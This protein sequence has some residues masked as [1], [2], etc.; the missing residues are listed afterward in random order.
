MNC[1]DTDGGVI[2]GKLTWEETSQ[3]DVRIDLSLFDYR[4]KVTTDYYRYT[5]GQ[6]N[7]VDLP[8][9]YFLNSNGKMHCCFRSGIEVELTADILR[10]SR[11]GS[12]EVENEI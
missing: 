5:K 12:Y 1:S 4:L 8:G 6:L 7:K 11:E 3:Y 10:N 2:T 9:I